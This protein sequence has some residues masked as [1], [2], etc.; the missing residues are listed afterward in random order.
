KRGVFDNQ[1]LKKLYDELILSGNSSLEAAF[2]AGAKV[3]EVDIRD[4]K[5][6]M[7]RTNNE[8]IKTTYSYL[9][10][11][12]ENHLRAFVRNL[13]RLG[14]DYIPVVMGKAEFDAIIS[15]DQGK[16]M[17]RG[18]GQCCEKPSVN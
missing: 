2:R 16:G 12:S 1:L 14:V 10:R 18:K 15:S 3:E 6:A 17:G 5:E 13:K 4:L 7:A 8:E 11:A 9:V